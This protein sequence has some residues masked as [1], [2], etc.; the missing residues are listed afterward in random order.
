[1]LIVACP[2]ALA[3]APPFA[4]GTAQRIMG[5]HGF[6]L[7][8][9]AVVEQLAR[10][11]AAVFDK[12]GTLTNGR[13]EVTDVLPARAFDARALLSLAGGIAARLRAGRGAGAEARP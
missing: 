2:C 3:L 7:K 12:T 10:V 9:P 11:D 6:Y 1:V 13:P 5:K 8:N 4:F